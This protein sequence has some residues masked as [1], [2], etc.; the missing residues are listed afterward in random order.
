MARSRQGFPSSWGRW[1]A[2]RLRVMAVGFVSK[3]CG[4]I[5]RPQ[6]EA[7]TKQMSS[8]LYGPHKE[9]GT[10]LSMAAMRFVRGPTRKFASQQLRR[11]DLCVVFWQIYKSV[12]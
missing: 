3:G 1:V 5:E 9:G 10:V 6:K 11:D 7:Q 4:G 2:S 12:F 8:R